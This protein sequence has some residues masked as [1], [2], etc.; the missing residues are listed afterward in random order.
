MPEKR[1]TTTKWVAG[2]AAK[3]AHRHTDIYANRVDNAYYNPNANGYNAANGYGSSAPPPAYGAYVPPP[4]ASHHFGAG[5]H[6]HS[7]HQQMHHNAMDMHN[8]AHNTAVS[9]ATHQSTMH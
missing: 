4:P 2:K 3:L 6:S 9:H 1:L 5:R 7:M 8:S